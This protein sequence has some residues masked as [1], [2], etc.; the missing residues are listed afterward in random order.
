MSEIPESSRIEGWI[1]VAGP[2]LNFILAAITLP[3]VGW[4]WASGGTF[5]V[6]DDWARYFLLT[7]ILLGG[8]NLLPAFPMDG[9]R[10][11]RAFLG[12]K[13]DWVLATQRAV[14]IGRAVAFGLA[15]SESSATVLRHAEPDVHLHRALRG[16]RR[17]SSAQVRARPASIRWRSSARTPARTKTGDPQQPASEYRARGA[18][19]G[20]ARR[21]PSP[22]K[23]AASRPRS[24][25]GSS[26]SA[27]RCGT[28]RPNRPDGGVQVDLMSGR[29]KLTV[30]PAASAGPLR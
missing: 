20:R 30:G 13:G 26:T 19:H 8:F 21:L 27:A 17:R 14:N 6:L 29:V 15:P 25:S 3:F 11:L 23:R 10:I 9:G 4:M 7:N 2:L 16:G 5:P 28:F 18:A 22:T 12:R 24:S 1:A